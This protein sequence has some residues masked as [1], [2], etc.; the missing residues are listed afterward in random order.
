M[1]GFLNGFDIY[2]VR[3]NKKVSNDLG[4]TSQIVK[5]LCKSLS[6]RLNFKIFVDNFFTSLEL[7]DELKKSAMYFLG[8]ARFLILK[9]CPLMAEKN[10]KKQGRGAIDYRVET[11]SNLIVVKWYDN[12]A[13]TLISSF[14]GIGPIAEIS[15]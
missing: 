4:I 11:N 8:T 12:K 5:S 6:S 3:S 13:I 2:Q 10:L 9:N 15:R 7:V 14:V 1:F